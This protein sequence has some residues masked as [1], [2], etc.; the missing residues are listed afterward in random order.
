VAVGALSGSTLVAANATGRDFL[1]IELEPGAHKTVKN[2]V[3]A[4]HI[5]R[6]RHPCR[7]DYPPWLVPLGQG[8]GGAST[9]TRIFRYPTGVL[10]TS[11]DTSQFLCE[12]ST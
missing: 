12:L 9:T 8:A 10:G 3:T 11:L 2:R 4:G 7:S 1:R 6:P 5:N